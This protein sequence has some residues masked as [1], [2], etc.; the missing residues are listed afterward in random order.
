LDILKA[1]NAV[2]GRSIL[3]VCGYGGVRNNLESF[4]DYPASVFSWAVNVEGVS[5]GRGRRLFGGKTVL[6]GFPNTEGSIIQTGT[7]LAVEE[8]TQAL[9]DEAGR[10]GVII[11]ADC[12]IPSD[13]PLER[14]G[15]IRDAAQA[16]SPKDR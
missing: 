9:L 13:T 15:W 7:K 14:L 3:H 8:F 4:K 5:L 6:G 12:T 10:T 2:G 1:A 11:G 16:G